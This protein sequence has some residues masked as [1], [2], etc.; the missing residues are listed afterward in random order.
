MPDAIAVVTGLGSVG[1]TSKAT[2]VSVVGNT[3]VL[4]ANALSGALNGSYLKIVVAT[5]CRTGGLTVQSVQYWKKN[6]SVLPISP[7][8]YVDLTSHTHTRSQNTSYTNV[9]KNIINDSEVARSQSYDDCSRAI[10]R[11]FGIYPPDQSKRLVLRWVNDAVAAARKQFS[12]MRGYLHWY[13]E[14]QGVYR[15]CANG[16]AMIGS[17]DRNFAIK[18]MG[19]AAEL[20]RVYVVAKGEPN[21][22]TELVMAVAFR[23]LSGPYG[24]EITCDDRSLWGVMTDRAEKDCDDLTMVACAVVDAIKRG[25]LPSNVDPVVQYIDDSF[26]AAYFVQGQA[27]P[28]VA[29]CPSGGHCFMLLE[30]RQAGGTSPNLANAL[31]VECTTPMGVPGYDRAVE[32][33]DGSLTVCALKPY[34][35]QKY[36]AIVAL[37]TATDTYFVR[38]DTGV[39]HLGASATDIIS[40]GRGDIYIER[41]PRLTRLPPSIREGQAYFF[42]ERWTQDMYEAL[43]KFRT[44]QKDILCRAGQA[45]WTSHTKGVFSRPVFGGSW[46]VLEGSTIDYTHRQP[47]LS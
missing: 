23:F 15:P 5:R 37:Y 38:R 7:N 3:F 28:N 21:P 42:Y 17:L 4:D 24:E 44:G 32:Q 35:L 34:D 6:Q 20:A 47:T 2:P 31:V 8:I 33:S 18:T 27:T 14:L 22:S 39:Q 46:A 13:S 29:Q 16:F 19:A 9:T 25:P 1:P 30:R 26:R 10:G 43:R 12:T 45:T 40:G 36:T 41:I 11:A